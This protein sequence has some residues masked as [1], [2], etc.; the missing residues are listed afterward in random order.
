MTTTQKQG[1]IKLGCTSCFFVCYKCKI[2]DVPKHYLVLRQAFL[3]ILCE[4]E[5]P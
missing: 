3:T 4:K 2:M 1:D 5:V